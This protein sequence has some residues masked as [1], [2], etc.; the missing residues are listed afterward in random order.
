MSESA[1]PL[2]LSPLHPRFGA[3]VEGIDL[4]RPMN[5]ATRDAVMAAFDEHSVLLFPGQV[6]DDAAQ[7]RFSE[8]SAP[9]RR[10]SPA[11]PI[12]APA[13]SSPTSPMWMPTAT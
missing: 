1:V 9:W 10:P 2:E 7:V 3:R 5:A 6:L 13:S 12:R 11:R 8:A 4:S